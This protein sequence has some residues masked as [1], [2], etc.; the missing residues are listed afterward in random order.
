MP[1]IRLSEMY[2][3]VAEC[4]KAT[5]ATAVARLN[6]VLTSRGYDDSELLDPVSVNSADAVQAEILNEYQREFIAEGQLFFYHKRMK[7]EKLNGYTVNYVFPK[8]DT[9]TEFGK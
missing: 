5:P 7:D 2:Y 8:P 4:D 1:M 3:I 9:E 6:E